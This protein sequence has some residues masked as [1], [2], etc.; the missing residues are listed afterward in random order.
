MPP[1]CNEPRDGQPFPLPTHR[2]VSGIPKSETDNE[3]WVYPSEQMFYNA[4]IRKGWQW[5]ESDIQAEDMTH[6]INIH[7]TNNELA[8]REVLKWE[9]LHA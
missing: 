5:K 9:A 2:H 6:I 7:N 1:L 8:W 4:M 3:H